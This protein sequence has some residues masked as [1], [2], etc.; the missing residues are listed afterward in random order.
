[1]QQLNQRRTVFDDEKI[2]QDTGPFEQAF[3]VSIADDASQ[4]AELID[5]NSA[6][7]RGSNFTS[8]LQ[9]SW[10]YKRNRAFQTHTPSSLA[11]K[12]P[13]S[14]QWPSAPAT[15]IFPSTNSSSSSSSSSNDNPVSSLDRSTDSESTPPVSNT[16]RWS[17]LTVLSISQVSNVS[18]INLPLNRDSL[19]SFLHSS[20]SW[21]NERIEFFPSLPR[22]L[23]RST[24]PYTI[25][26]SICTTNPTLPGISGPPKLETFAEGKALP[27]AEGESSWYRCTSCAHIL[28]SNALLHFPDGSTLCNSCTYMCHSCGISIKSTVY[29][30]HDTTLCGDCFRCR[31]CK[32]RIRGNQFARTGR[33]FWCLTCYDL[34]R[35]RRERK[36]MEELAKVMEER[37]GKKALR[38]KLVS[39][40][41]RAT[42]ARS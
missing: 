38:R 1:M 29:I 6:M 34:R 4:T 21:S 37:Q 7:V 23:T 18:V 25:C 20:H 22:S 30:I 8:Y 40:L 5:I 39:G 41:V 14:S 19:S 11:A 32:R 26:S 36:R 33:G 42:K 28:P 9:Q 13:T 15:S 35:K 10:V 12:S 3:T 17:A 16:F 27:L 24:K 31:N 2:V